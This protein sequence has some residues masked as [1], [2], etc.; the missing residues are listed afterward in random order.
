[1]LGRVNYGGLVI[2][3][4]G[5]FLTRFTVS[6]AVSGDPMA[7]YFT[8]VVPLALGLGLSAFGV[9]LTVADVDAATV[10]TAARWCVVGL[11]TMLAL[12]VLTLLGS[13]TG[14]TGWVGR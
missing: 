11:V 14:E 13:P 4:I 9:A 1:M 2:A 6:L 8:G 10:R 7:F 5:F 3:G 12:V